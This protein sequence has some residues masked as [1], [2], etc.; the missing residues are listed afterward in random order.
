MPTNVNNNQ[1][2]SA[3][4]F[5]SGVDLSESKHQTSSTESIENNTHLTV[6]QLD[7]IPEIND[8]I[9]DDFNVRK[10]SFSNK[11]IQDFFI[12][13]MD[14]FDDLQLPLPLP[15]MQKTRSRSIGGFSD[16]KSEIELQDH[17]IL[18]IGEKG[19]SLEGSINIATIPAN[20]KIYLLSKPCQYG[21]C[22]S[23]ATRLCDNVIGSFKGCGSYICEEHVKIFAE[24]EEQN[25]N[26][27]VAYH[28]D[29]IDACSADVE[30]QIQPKYI[31]KHICCADPK[32]HL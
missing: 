9:Q 8:R 32:C 6:N 19:T 31:E 20:N 15:S 2:M 17:I 30:N 1:V 3:Q 12:Q 26:H 16:K 27:F 4:D 28:I 10:V 13:E 18:D 11:N 23:I 24:L 29:H 14:M 21:G 7:L 22:T 5:L 25:N